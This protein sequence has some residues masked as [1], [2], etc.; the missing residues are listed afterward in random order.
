MVDCGANDARI[1]TILGCGG[2]GIGRP[3]TL[4]IEKELTEGFAPD[5][6][7]R[8]NTGNQKHEGMAHNEA[9]EFSATD[10]VGR[11]RAIQ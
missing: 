4:F 2:M 8:V 3:D 6:S 9:K 1:R 11:R 10:G 7:R 5:P